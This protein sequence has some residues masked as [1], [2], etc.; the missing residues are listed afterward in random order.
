[1]GESEILGNTVN[2]LPRSDCSDGKAYNCKFLRSI[3]PQRLHEGTSKNEALFEGLDKNVSVCTIEN[4]CWS[5]YRPDGSNLKN[6]ANGYIQD[7]VK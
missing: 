5:K 4:M 2:G 1:M 7:F 6:T 3:L